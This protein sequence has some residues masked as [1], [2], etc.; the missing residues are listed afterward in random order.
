VR[1]GAVIID[2]SPA[3]AGAATAE[4]GPAGE[5]IVSEQSV[6]PTIIVP[7]ERDV[8][9]PGPGVR[10]PL[11][12]APPP[13]QLAED[14]KTI[15]INRLN[16]VR[17]AGWQRALHQQ[18]DE[19]YK[20]VTTEFSSPPGSA[21]HMLTLLQEARQILL[22]SPE[23]YVAAEYRIAQVRSTMSRT[24]ESR[25]QSAHLA[26]RVFVYEVVWLALLLLGLVFAASLAGIFTRAGNIAGATASDVFPFWNTLMWGGIGGIIGALYALWWHV[27]DQQDFDRQYMMWY[28]V[29]P[30][31]GVVLGG[32]V[33]L[34]LTG[35]FL[36]LQIKPSDPNAGARLLP[37]LVAVLA[38][39]RQ[40]FIYN[41]LDRLIG[42]FASSGNQSSGGQG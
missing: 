10:P 41:Q 16:E 1:I 36:L 18:I 20:Q 28:L 6:V 34:L 19:L 7:G 23:N 26:P 27:S 17:D 33:F 29:Q 38:G 13:Q 40:N 39:F 24:R 32:I 15:I 8:L 5:L 37:Y 11:Q 4:V 30:I 3:G 12:P 35:G 31:M 42:L 21:D 9:P 25:L 14:Q 22:E 2:G